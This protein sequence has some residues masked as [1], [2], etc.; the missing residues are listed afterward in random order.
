M[1]GGW[2]CGTSQKRIV[3][4]GRASS[5]VDGY[6]KAVGGFDLSSETGRRIVKRFVDIDVLVG[7]GR[8]GTRG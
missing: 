4:R 3:V 1:H 2:A 8:V 6:A 5:D 7:I